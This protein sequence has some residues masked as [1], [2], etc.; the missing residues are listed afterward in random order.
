MVFVS[1]LRMCDFST[2]NVVLFVQ[3]YKLVHH[4]FISVLTYWYRG[5][6][7]FSGPIPNSMQA[8]SRTLISLLDRDFDVVC[9]SC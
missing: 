2:F 5:G 7:V 8:D 9:N 4:V 3:S 6:K 1:Q